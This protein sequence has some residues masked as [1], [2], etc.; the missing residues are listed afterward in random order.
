MQRH[1]GTVAC[2][3]TGGSVRA[4]AVRRSKAQREADE[5]AR[6]AALENDE[7]QRRVTW[8]VTYGAP[9]MI[10]DGYDPDTGTWSPTSPIGRILTFVGNGSHLGVAA[11]LAGVYR[12]S[13]LYARGAEYDAEAAD[14]TDLEP[15]ERVFADLFRQITIAESFFEVNTVA[16][17]TKRLNA[18]PDLAMKFLARRFP[19]RWREQTAMLF[20]EERDLTDDAITNAISDPNVAMHL[21]AVA[22]SVESARLAEDED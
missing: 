13:N 21:A 18:D 3:T 6:Q 2:E 11:N 16:N 14:R 19:A 5:A 17:I 8:S 10:L 22:A 20:P 7:R 9:I 1:Q 4:V 15:D 12:I